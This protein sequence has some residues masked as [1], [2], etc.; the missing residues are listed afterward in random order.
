[1]CARVRRR[2]RK[3]VHERRAGGS[4]SAGALV[5]SHGAGASKGT[6]RRA[7]LLVILTAVACSRSKPLRPVAAPPPSPA[8]APSVGPPSEPPPEPA[9]RSSERFQRERDPRGG[10]VDEPATPSPPPPLDRPVVDPHDPP[11]PRPEPPK[12]KRHEIEIERCII[13]GAPIRTPHGLKAR[14]SCSTR[15]DTKPPTGK[16]CSEIDARHYRCTSVAP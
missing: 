10:Y 2:L 4:A 5:N 8:P 1:M 14:R 13:G 15:C 11:P 3:F 12:C 9:V 16:R 7:L 6:M